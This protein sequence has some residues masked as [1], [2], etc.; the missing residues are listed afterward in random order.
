MPV[1]VLASGALRAGTEVDPKGQNAVDEARLSIAEHGEVHE[2]EVSLF[3]ET[4][5]F[6][7]FDRGQSASADGLG[8]VSEPG[9][10]GIGI[11]FG[12]GLGW[13]GARV[14]PPW[15]DRGA[16]HTLRVGQVHCGK[17]AC[18]HQTS[19]AGA[20]ETAVEVLGRCRPV[21]RDGG[22]CRPGSWRRDGGGEELIR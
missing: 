11:E 13:H 3:G 6:G 1:P 7:P 5:P 16:A 14:S 4:S 15:R 22:R 19:D 8:P 21:G 12:L 18:R 17:A 2:V 10:H 9:D 20:E